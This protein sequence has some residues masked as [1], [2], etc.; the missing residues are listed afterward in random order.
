[1]LKAE[2]NLLMSRECVSVS[3]PV[4]WPARVRLLWLYL[5]SPYYDRLSF[6]MTAVDFI[7]MQNYVIDACVVASSFKSQLFK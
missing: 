3:E 4:G 6:Y 7:G 1:M 5:V 2:L